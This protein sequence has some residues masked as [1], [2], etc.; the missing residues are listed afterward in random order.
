MKVKVKVFN[1]NRTYTLLCVG[2]IIIKKTYWL[3][4]N[5]P[6]SIKSTALEHNFANRADFV[7]YAGTD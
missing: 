2:Q 7:N 5:C 3:A 6:D 1:K 4:G